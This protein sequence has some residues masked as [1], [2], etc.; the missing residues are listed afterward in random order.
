MSASM[1]DKFSAHECSDARRADDYALVQLPHQPPSV[2]P[3]DTAFPRRN[4]APVAAA[5]LQ[6]RSQAR[7]PPFILHHILAAHPWDT[8]KPPVHWDMGSEPRTLLLNQPGWR[9]DSLN[10]TG[11]QSC[12][13]VKNIMNERAIACCALGDWPLVGRCFASLRCYNLSM[14]RLPWEWTVGQVLDALRAYFL[15]G[16][17][18]QVKKDRKDRTFR[19]I[20]AIPDYDNA[21]DVI[22]LGG[23]TT[24]RVNL[25]WRCSCFHGLVIETQT[26][27]EC[28]LR[29]LVGPHR[30][31]S[32]A[33]AQ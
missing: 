26:D 1:P 3:I 33:V 11:M 20:P 2:W 32:R 6:P 22:G 4:G 7:H 25:L 19:F 16:S 14:G 28:D 30:N 23:E 24:K 13:I 12:E 10:A 18:S 29:V 31:G 5:G 21:M 8:T 17:T 9:H 15:H 27:R